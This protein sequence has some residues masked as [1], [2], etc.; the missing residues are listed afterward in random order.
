MEY[1]NRSLLTIRDYKRLINHIADLVEENLGSLNLGYTNLVGGLLGQMG[2]LLL[3]Y[4][5]VLG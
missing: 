5:Y 3:N 2:E 1:Q 4:S